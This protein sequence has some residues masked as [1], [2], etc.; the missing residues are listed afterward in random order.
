[1]VFVRFR[2]AILAGFLLIDA[3]VFASTV[4]LVE[5]GQMS[6][7]RSDV[8]R[9]LE[10]ARLVIDHLLSRRA[11]ELG[12]KARLLAADFAIRQSLAT[13]DSATIKSN[14]MSL[15][16]RL[17]ADA[18]WLVDAEGRLFGDSPARQA[19]AKADG[20]K[21]LARAVLAGESPVRLELVG[22]TPYQLAAVPIN[23]PDPIGGVI[24][25]FEAGDAM[26]AELRRLTGVHV[27]FV[28]EGRVFASTLAPD[29]RK[30]LLSSAAA[31]APGS[32]AE[33]GAA[34]DQYLVETSVLSPSIRVYVQQSLDDALEPAR[35][36]TR[37]LTV[38]ALAALAVIALLGYLLAVAVS[39]SVQRLVDELAQTNRFQKQFFSVVV[40]DVS[41][42]LSVS[43]G[44]SE[45]LRAKARDPEDIRLIDQI[46]GAL[47][48]MQ[49]LVSDLTD[50]ASIE[51]GKL[52]VELADIDLLPVLDEMKVRAEL[53][54]KKR[55]IAFTFE[56]PGSL[57]RI[58]GDARRLAQVVQNLCSNATHYTP[59]GGRVAL[60][61][62]RLDG[63]LR[64]SVSDSGIG[65]S[66]QDLGKVFNRFFQADNAMRFRGK[67]LGLGLKI[68]RE[69]VEAHGGSIK[70]E[71][72]LAKGSTFSFT[73]PVP[74]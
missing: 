35:R 71:S 46:S 70:V 58:R 41:N 16:G 19:A 72:E 20:L 51:S 6:Q 22:G 3:G 26:A 52:R 63:S 33:I 56:A 13:G 59:K 36:L 9:R 50:F 5:R 18:L 15:R 66:K 48:T 39:R 24:A 57:P 14:A 7:A 34:G 67:G 65:I 25:G 27:S 38:I 42:P 49:F 23:A 44:Y 2:L 73:V 64:I 30:R 37:L 61:V 28:S 43:Q 8:T 31:L 4:R 1:M 12:T 45:L 55:D 10:L 54:A 60:K 21:G 29:D 69:I 11:L 68:A 40:H 74:P 62:E 47:G 17:Q 53:L 32:A